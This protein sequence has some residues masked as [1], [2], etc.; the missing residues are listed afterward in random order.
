MQHHNSD[1]AEKAS[2]HMTDLQHQIAWIQHAL[3]YTTPIPRDELLLPRDREGQ[4]ARQLTPAPNVTPRES[5]ALLL[6]YP[7]EGELWLPLTVRSTALPQHRGE[8]SLPGGATDPEDDGPV[9]TALRETCEEVGIAPQAIEVWGLLTP[10]YI[11]PSN[12]RLTPVVGFAASPIRLQP[13]PHEITDVF[14]VPLRHLLDSTTVVVEEWMLHG[15]QT[16]VPFFALHGHKVWGAT[17]LVLS[18]LVARLRRVALEMG[19]PT[20]EP[21]RG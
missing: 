12:F 2:I 13:N 20:I 4:I 19:H 10:I 17:A 3:A 14:T 7:D 6:F 8:V 15:I 11:P 1:R 18:E 5:A 9:S 16:Q 21:N